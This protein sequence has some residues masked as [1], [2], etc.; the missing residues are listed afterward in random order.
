MGD[1]DKQRRERGERP[2]PPSSVRR[3]QKPATF[4]EP[5]FCPRVSLR[6]FFNKFLIIISVNNGL[7]VFRNGLRVFLRS[8]K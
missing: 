1:R 2:S 8:S 5:D 4:K 3:G 6:N 7:R